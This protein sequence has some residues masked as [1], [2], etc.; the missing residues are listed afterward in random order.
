[1]STR[2]GASGRR[3]AESTGPETPPTRPSTSVVDRALHILGS[4][5]EDRPRQS[6]SDISRNT[7]IP[8]ATVHRIVKRLTA[9]GALERDTTGRYRIGLRLWEVGSLTHRAMDLQRIARPYLHELFEVTH[10]S[11]HLAIREGTEAVFVERFHSPRQTHLTPRIGGRYPIHATAVGLV[12]LAHAPDEVQQTV[13]AG[14]LERY[15]E[16]THADPD[17]LSRAL[18]EVRHRGYAVSDRQVS[19]DYLAVA[20]PVIS[21]DGVVIAALSL[22]LD[23]HEADERSAIHLVRLTANNISRALS[24]QRHRSTDV[25]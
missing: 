14:D 15:T 9:W 10:Y 4:F 19:L 20:A 16:F 3:G 5:E 1:M 21:A 22:I 13:L 8:V 18:A 7:R 11:I 6:L 17:A 2:A 23:P 24:V 12:L 25:S